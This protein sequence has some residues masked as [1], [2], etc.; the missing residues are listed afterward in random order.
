MST[1]TVYQDRGSM[2]FKGTGQFCFYFNLSSSIHEYILRSQV[3]WGFLKSFELSEPIDNVVEYIPDLFFRKMLFPSISGLN[4]FHKDYI[5]WLIVKL[6]YSNFVLLQFNW[7]KEYKYTIPCYQ[8]CIVKEVGYYLCLSTLTSCLV[9]GNRINNGD[10]N[11]LFSRL[12]LSMFSLPLARSKFDRG[13]FSGNS[14][15]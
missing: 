14:K 4:F 7:F 9:F 10:L 15:S 3:T 1:K 12:S 2:F 13:S 5:I 6:S 8:R 11:C